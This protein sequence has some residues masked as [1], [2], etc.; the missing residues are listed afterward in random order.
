MNS[1]ELIRLLDLAPLPGEGGFYRET[2]RTPTAGNARAAASACYYLVTPESFSALHRLKQDEVFHFYLGA[3]VEMFQI[4][5][6]GL[7]R[8]RILG[9]DLAEGQSPQTLVPQGTWQGARLL[10][11]GARPGWALLGCT[12]A[13]AFEFSDLEIGDRAALCAAYPGLASS[14]ERFT[15]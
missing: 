12:V 4:D 8:S 9:T 6:Q 7:G 13:P 5:P 14:I 3:P 10:E 2:Y 1:R 15:R 11:D